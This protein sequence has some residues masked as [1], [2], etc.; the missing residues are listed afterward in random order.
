MLN[1]FGI[2]VLPTYTCPMP[3]KEKKSERLEM[4]VT[5]EFKA[6]VKRYADLQGRSVNSYIIWAVERML[7]KV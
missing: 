6:K 5:P 4:K 1:K 3:A 2:S 7:G